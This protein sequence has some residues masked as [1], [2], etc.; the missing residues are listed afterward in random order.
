VKIVLDK[1]T[2]RGIIVYTI[3]I[4]LRVLTKGSYSS[5]YTLP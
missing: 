1:Y 4:R 5:S 3:S 2:D